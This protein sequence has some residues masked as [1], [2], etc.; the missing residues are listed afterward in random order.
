MIFKGIEILFFMLGVLTTLGISALIYYN[1]KLK[2]NVVTW[3]ILGFGLFLLIF[4][5]AWSFSSILEG[6][7]RA[8]SMGMI[9]FGIPSIILLVFG[10]RLAVKKKAN[11]K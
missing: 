5:I 4:S 6:E 1:G 3:L 9:V 10:R 2:F 11:L 8:A 7:P